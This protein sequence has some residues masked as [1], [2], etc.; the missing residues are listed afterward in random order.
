V[1][2]WERERE[3]ERGVGVVL[4]CEGVIGHV[5]AA[6]LLALLLHEKLPFISFF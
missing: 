6:T 3:R 2:F 4:N 1:T 5:H